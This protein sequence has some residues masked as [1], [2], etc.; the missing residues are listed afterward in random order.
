MVAVMHLASLSLLAVNAWSVFHAIKNEF[1][2]LELPWKNVSNLMDS[3]NAM[4]GS[5]NEFETTVW[6]NLTSHF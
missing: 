6:E 4:R 1:E 5:K 3:C 2:N